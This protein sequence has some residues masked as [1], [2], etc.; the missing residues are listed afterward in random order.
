MLKRLLL[1]P[2]LLVTTAGAVEPSTLPIESRQSRFE[3]IAIEL[4]P[5][6]RLSSHPMCSAAPSKPSDTLYLALREQTADSLPSEVEI[7]ILPSRDKNAF[8]LPEA[9][10]MP[11]AVL[12]SS[13]L[14]DESTSDSEFAFI[15]AHEF[16]H[17]ALGHLATSLDGFVLSPVQR[18]KVERVHKQWEHSADSFAL[19]RM[20]STGF[21]TTRAIDL[22]DHLPEP[23]ST[24]LTLHPSY[25]ERRLAMRAQMQ[26][27]TPSGGELL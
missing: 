20:Q 6:Y 13:A 17:L 10:D 11:A 9:P 14:F 16:G 12:V 27:E 8:A 18:E 2:Y 22:W 1:L 21:A 7:H 23:I 24:T 26:N 4:F 5:E 25:Q 15:L 3:R 19:T